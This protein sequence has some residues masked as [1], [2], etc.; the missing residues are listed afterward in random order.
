MHVSPS[1]LLSSPNL[2]THACSSKVLVFLIY[3]S[4]SLFTNVH[5]PC[6]FKPFVVGVVTYLSKH[7]FHHFCW[8]LLVTL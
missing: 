4:H 3:R 1:S 7:C 8:V 5:V 6:V 2:H